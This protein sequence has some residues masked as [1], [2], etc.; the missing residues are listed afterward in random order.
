MRFKPKPDYFARFATISYLGIHALEGSLGI[1]LTS[2]LVMSFEKNNCSKVMVSA[3][4]KPL[5]LWV[6]A[7]E[8]RLVIDFESGKCQASGMLTIW[9]SY[10]KRHKWPP[11]LAQLSQQPMQ[12]STLLEYQEDVKCMPQSWQEMWHLNGY[13][14]YIYLEVL[15]PKQLNLEWEQ[16]MPFIWWSTKSNFFLGILLLCHQKEIAKTCYMYLTE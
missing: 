14:S 11:Q 7:M 12:Q 1:L 3:Y 2:L 8:F 5:N 6:I 16:L 13:W 10:I 4:S 9:F 15:L